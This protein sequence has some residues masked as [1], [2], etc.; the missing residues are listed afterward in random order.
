M[1]FLI[2]GHYIHMSRHRKPTIRSKKRF[3]TEYFTR[4]RERK[5]H[6]IQFFRESNGFS[7]TKIAWPLLR[8]TYINLAHR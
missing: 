1:Q 7:H 8:G 3:P 2:L 4:K 6:D 5:F